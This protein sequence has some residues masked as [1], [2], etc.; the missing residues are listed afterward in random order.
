[1]FNKL[2]NFFKNLFKPKKALPAP[3][4][5]PIEESNSI[6][7]TIDNVEKSNDN[8]DF[9][10]EI[11]VEEKQEDPELLDLQ[12]RFESNQI[13]ITDLTNEQ[14]NALNELYTRQIDA[15]TKKIDNVTTEINI[16]EQSGKKSA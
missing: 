5:V 12:E 9:K 15:L 6:D 4:E 13:K 3:D 11:K 16:L 10:S 2:F 1:M 7:N 14:L 8:Q